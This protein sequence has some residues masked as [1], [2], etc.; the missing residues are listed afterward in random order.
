MW[1]F[2][3]LYPIGLP[4]A[5]FFSIFVLEFVTILFIRTR[6]SIKYF[7]KFI[8]LINIW[9]LFYCNSYFYGVMYEA[10]SF[11]FC[12]SMFIFVFFVKYWELESQNNW[13]P[14]GNLTPSM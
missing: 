1:L 3:G 12:F 4:E 8:T 6:S 9:F 13:N 7:P 2:P 14:F 11:I 5:Y 10:Y